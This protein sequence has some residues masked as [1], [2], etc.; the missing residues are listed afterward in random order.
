MPGI[1]RAGQRCR[2][3]LGI[4][5]ETHFSCPDCKVPYPIILVFNITLHEPEQGKYSRGQGW[6]GGAFLS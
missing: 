5:H 3:E 6:G 2:L 1:M 4:H